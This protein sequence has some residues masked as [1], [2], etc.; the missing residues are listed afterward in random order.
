MSVKKKLDRT[1]NGMARVSIVS[2][3]GKGKMSELNNNNDCDECD[4]K[5]TAFHWASIG[6]WRSRG[7]ATAASFY[8]HTLRHF[9]VHSIIYTQTP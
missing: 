9:S 7:S 6:M 4:G 2:F 8:F 3:K 5:S 1:E